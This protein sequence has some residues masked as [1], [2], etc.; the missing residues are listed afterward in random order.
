MLNSFKS[1]RKQ[2]SKLKGVENQKLGSTK[3]DEQMEAE[4]M[5]S[6]ESSELDRYGEGWR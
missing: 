2:G 1:S 4:R 6:D 5:C 3:V